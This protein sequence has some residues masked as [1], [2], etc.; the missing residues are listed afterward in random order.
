MKRVLLLALVLV[1][2]VVA[3]FAQYDA[4]AKEHGKA[5][6]MTGW[7]CSSKCVVTQNEHSTCNQACT[8][9]GDPVWVDENGS[10]MKISKS[11][12]KSARKSMGKHVKVMATMDDQD[13]ILRL[14]LLSN[15]P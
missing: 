13:E 15:N 14:E 3:S 4:P 9:P 2:G 7:V 11:A 12:M 5:K 8:Q 6:P 10:M 1:G